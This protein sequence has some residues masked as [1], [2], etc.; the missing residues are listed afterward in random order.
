MKKYLQLERIEKQKKYTAGRLEA[1][2]IKIDTLERWDG[3]IK[4]TSDLMIIYKMKKK[5]CAIPSGTYRIVLT[6]S[7]RFSSRNFY[8]NYSSGLLP[9]LV[10]VKGFEGV[11]IHCGNT[12]LDTAGCI[13]VG[14]MCG[15]GILKNSRI[16]YIKLFRLLKRWWDNGD[17]IYIKIK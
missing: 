5:E 16:N 10:G 4:S 3:G 9:R 12:V 14:E 6:Y 13:L 8:K 7:N 2:G 1:E 11:L 15:P 17:E